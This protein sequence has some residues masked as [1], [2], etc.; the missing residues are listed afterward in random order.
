MRNNVYLLG[1]FVVKAIGSKR[2]RIKAVESLEAATGSGIVGNMFFVE[3]SDFFIV[4]ATCDAGGIDGSSSRHDENGLA[5][6]FVP[7]CIKRH[8]MTCIDTRRK[9]ES[10]NVALIQNHAAETSRKVIKKRGKINFFPRKKYF[11]S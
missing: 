7:S 5:N 8:F 6:T 9:E 11:G 4:D 2:L 3:N 10:L 1:S